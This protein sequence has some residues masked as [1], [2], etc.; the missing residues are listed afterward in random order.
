M[1]N[2]LGA[3]ITWYHVFNLT[4]L[5]ICLYR[6]VPVLCCKRQLFTIVKF[7]YIFCMFIYNLIRM[8]SCLYTN[9]CAWYCVIE[10][11]KA[12]LSCSNMYVGRE[13]IYG[14]MRAGVCVH[15]CNR[16][17]MCVCFVCVICIHKLKMYISVYK[18]PRL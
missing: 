5:F 8:Q 10:Y 18:Y 16:I 4:S 13:S 3:I 17:C 15:V 7:Y 14:G 12:Y 11:M 2:Y 9:K 6:H 1:C